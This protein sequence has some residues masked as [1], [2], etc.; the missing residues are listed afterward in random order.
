M[1][2]PRVLVFVQSGCPHCHEYRKRFDPIASRLASR[3]IPVHMGDIARDSNARRY[4]DRYRVRAT[5]TT[6]GITRRGRLIR[7]EGAVSDAEVT[8]MFEQVLVIT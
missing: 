7:L 2:G 6:I 4:A 8:R 3:K 5:P 1:N